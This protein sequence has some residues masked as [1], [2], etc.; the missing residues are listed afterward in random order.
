MSFLLN[1]DPRHDIVVAQEHRLILVV[2]NIIE[3]KNFLNNSVWVRKKNRVV[4][5]LVTEKVLLCGLFGI[6]A[7]GDSFI[8]TVLQVLEVNKD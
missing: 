7:Q 4:V 1:S 2:K 6:I 8:F 5:C 3:V